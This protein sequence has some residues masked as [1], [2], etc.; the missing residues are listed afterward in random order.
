MQANA[1]SV[2][3]GVQYGEHPLYVYYILLGLRRLKVV[4]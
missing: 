1:T 2:C 4:L 3:G